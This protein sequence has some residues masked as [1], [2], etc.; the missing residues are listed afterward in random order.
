MNFT[1]N[2]F[3]LTNNNNHALVLEKKYDVPEK[4]KI[5]INFNKIKQHKE[6]LQKDLVQMMKKKE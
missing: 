1:K 6:Q 2:S 3:E 5:T 4:Y